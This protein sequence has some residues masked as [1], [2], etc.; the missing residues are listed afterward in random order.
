MITHYRFTIYGC[1]QSHKST[2]CFP[3]SVQKY[4]SGGCAMNEPISTLKRNYSYDTFLSKPL[5]SLFEELTSRLNFFFILAEINHFG[6][7][8]SIQK[9]PR[10]LGIFPLY[11]KFLNRIQTPLRQFGSFQS[12]NVCFSKK[13][14]PYISC[15]DDRIVLPRH[16]KSFIGRKTRLKLTDKEKY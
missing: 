2:L 8:S 15:C 14:P 3:C 5:P 9:L 1:H 13:Y 10:Q 12:V 6:V 7:C 4:W 16:I 11:K